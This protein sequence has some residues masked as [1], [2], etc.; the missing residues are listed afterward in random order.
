MTILMMRISQSAVKVQL[1]NTLQG[2]EVSPL[3][4]M[5]VGETQL[6][7]DP[8]LSTSSTVPTRKYRAECVS[9]RRVTR[10]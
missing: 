2:L 5:K 8:Q 3:L 7:N 4:Q 9:P 10:S 1:I 6:A